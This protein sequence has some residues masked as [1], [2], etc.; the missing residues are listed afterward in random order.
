MPSPEVL[1]ILGFVAMFLLLGMGIHVGISMA[2]VGFIGTG[3][4]MGFSRSL[5]M[6]V[7]TPYF[8]VSDYSFVVLPMFLLMGELAFQGGIGVLLYKAA[9]KWLGNIKG[10][11]AMA[12]TAA[13]ALLGA[14]TGSTLAA[15]ATFSKLAVPEM[16][17][18]NYDMKLAS[19]V[20][21]ASGTLAVLIP[22]SGVMVLYTILAE[23][24]SLGK[25]M[26]AGFIPGIISAILYMLMIYGRVRYNPS[27]A[28]PLDETVTWKERIFAIRWLTPVIVV[29]IGMLGGIYT[30]V[31]SPIEAGAVGAFTVFVVVLVRRSLSFSKFK[32]AV[33]NTAISTGMICLVI[34]GAMVFGRFLMLTG[35]P[36]ALLSFVSGLDIP[37]LGILVV[38]LL[39]YIVLGCIMDVPAMLVITIPMFHPM[40]HGLG[41]DDIWVAI[42][43]IKIVEV[44][45]ITP[46]IGMNVYVVKSVLG[47]VVSIGDLFR[48][49]L[50]FFII[51]VLTLAI[52]VAL[53]QISLWLPSTMYK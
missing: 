17:R 21:A 27:L 1:G 24:V 4:M 47:D 15:A 5:S 34:V 8:T 16:R 35:L 38:I 41:L 14:V 45:A 40:L 18:Y 3:M 48:G 28:P 26:I 20:V 11:L 39:I 2:V 42:L 53:P 50:P 22:P 43:V 13:N 52:L 37:P 32:E 30:G 6:L 36:E 46:P 10:G 7:T 23:Q 51:D 31:F 49:I 44:A 25:L 12:T 29:L 9:A 19:G 33:I